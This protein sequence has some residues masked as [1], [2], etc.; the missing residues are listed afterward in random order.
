M[1][2]YDEWPEFE[3]EN[4]FDWSLSLKQIERR[5]RPSPLMPD[6]Y[7]MGKKKGEDLS[8][9]LGRQKKFFDE[10]NRQL[11]LRKKNNL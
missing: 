2:N 9:P 7:F 4:K 1:D 3:P 11:E 6:H 8:D 5:Y 10:M